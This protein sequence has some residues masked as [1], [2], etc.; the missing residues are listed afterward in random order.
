LLASIKLKTAVANKLSELLG[1]RH[2]TK[3][4]TS[5]ESIAL[6]K[7]LDRLLIVKHTLHSG[8]PVVAVEDA[9]FTHFL[10]KASNLVAIEAGDILFNG[11]NVYFHVQEKTDAGFNLTQF[12]E[13][14]FNLM[15]AN[16]DN[17]TKEEF[18]NLYVKTINC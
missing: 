14:V 18:E 10:K 8:N 7:K 9:S 13:A 6:Q 1:F 4:E 2:N 12:G 11:T 16:K 15:D 3:V 5:E 17:Y